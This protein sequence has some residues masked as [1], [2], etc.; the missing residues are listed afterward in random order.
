MIERLDIEE[1][2]NSPK[3]YFDASNL[4][5][6]IEGESR[7]ENVGD[8]YEPVLGWID[9]YLEW[10]LKEEKEV[11]ATFKLNLVFA[12][13]SSIKMVLRILQAL[14]KIT[15][16]TDMVFF[17]YH[18][19]HERDD[20]DGLQLGQELEELSELQFSYIPG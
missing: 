10:L 14:K 16:Q 19:H 12:N 8:F 9:D 1:T 15:D 5:F 11:E 18:W 6:L 13:S 3:V 7:P 4:I 2:T 17:D 20:S